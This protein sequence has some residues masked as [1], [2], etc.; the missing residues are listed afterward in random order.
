MNDAYLVA[1]RAAYL[2]WFHWTPPKGAKGG[3]DGLRDA[4]WSHVARAA[5]EAY[6]AATG[7]SRPQP[8]VEQAGPC[9]C[10]HPKDAH[11][12][13]AYD[14]WCG[15]QGRSCSCK[16]YSPSRSDNN[17]SSKTP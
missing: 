13:D 6:H 8:P 10:G 1:G 4:L 3:S 14:S 16:G 17:A 9:V 5:V 11:F 2:A 12:R 15:D 7:T